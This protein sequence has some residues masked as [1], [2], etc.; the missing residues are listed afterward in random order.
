MFE[1]AGTLEGV[2][3]PEL[4]DKDVCRMCKT[5][6]TW[7]GRYWEHTDYSPRNIGEPE[8]GLTAVPL[9][10]LEGRVEALEAEVESIKRIM[11]AR[12]I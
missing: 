3:M 12:G 4:G 7:T 2:N 5:P 10:T 8:R 1:A 6:I 9:P 11:R